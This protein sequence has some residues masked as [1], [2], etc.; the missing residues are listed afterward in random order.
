MRKKFQSRQNV[1]VKAFVTP[2]VRRIFEKSKSFRRKIAKPVVVDDDDIEILIPRTEKRVENKSIDGER[3]NVSHVFDDGRFLDRFLIIVHP[4][5]SVFVKYFLGDLFF[6]FSELLVDRRNVIDVRGKRREKFYEVKF[7]TQLHVD[8][9][10]LCVVLRSRKI[11]R[12]FPFVRP[13]ELF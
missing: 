11:F 4:K 3:L 2:I 12:N 6:R 10:R 9:R 13:R 7:D 8:Q 5:V 1:N